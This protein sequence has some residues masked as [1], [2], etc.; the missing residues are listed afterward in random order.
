VSTGAAARSAIGA[1]AGLPYQQKE[2]RDGSPA[3]GGV[4]AAAGG[5]GGGVGGG[6]GGGGASRR[7]GFRQRVVLCREAHARAVKTEESV[8]SLVRFRCSAA[9]K[10]FF[11]KILSVYPFIHHLFMS[12]F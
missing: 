12:F 2:G 6:S 10:T 7:K 4:F 1:G 11:P 3:S 8:G 5:R 9:V